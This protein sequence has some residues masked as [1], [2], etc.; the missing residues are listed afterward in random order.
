MEWRIDELAAQEQLEAIRPD[1]DGNQI[2]DLL[3]LK[4]GREVGEAYRYLLERRLDRGP[5]APQVAQAELLEWW[6]ART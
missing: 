6:A 1:L 4:P 3:G 2:M 5:V